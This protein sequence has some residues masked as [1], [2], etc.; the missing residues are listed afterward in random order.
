MP[1]A[2]TPSEIA[3]DTIRQLAQRR[4]APTPD[5]YGRVYH[6]LAGTSPDAA[7]GGERDMAQLLREQMAKLLVD[8]VVPRLGYGEDLGREARAIA[9]GVRQARKP[10]EL[11][12]QAAAL[13]QFQIV[14]HRLRDKAAAR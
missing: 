1:A 3:R 8:A 10:A 9:D 11:Q 14:V 6:E 12:D 4:L 13:R 2:A 5:N 7:S